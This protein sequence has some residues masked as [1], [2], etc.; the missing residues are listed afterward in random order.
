MAEQLN[1][2]LGK[3]TTADFHA[4][5]AYATRVQGPKTH[6]TSAVAPAMAAITTPGKKRSKKAEGSGVVKKQRK[7]TSAKATRP[8]NSYMAFRAYYSPIFSNFQQ[9]AI[10]PLLTLLWQGDHFQAKWTILAKA[11]SKIRDQQGKD[12][13]NLSKFLELV[14]PFIGIIA[15]ADYLSTM[16]W[17]M[18]EGENGAA[19]HRETTPDFSSFPAELRTT[20]VFVEDV[21]EYLQ[22][23]GYVA[24][25]SI[26]APGSA[27]AAPTLTMA[28]QPSFSSAA[29]AS[30]QANHATS[31]QTQLGHAGNVTDPA[32]MAPTTSEG[33][34]TGPNAA[35]GV[36]G[37]G[38]E[39]FYKSFENIVAELN[40]FDDQLDFNAEFYPSNDNVAVFNPGN[41]QF[42]TCD[43]TSVIDA[44]LNGFLTE[45][46][47]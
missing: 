17:K 30:M 15:P 3:L 7:E 46:V 21:I 44:D 32:L 6:G 10:S 33:V 23:I 24:N 29:Q 42:A 31:P 19:L 26:A 5:K 45:N 9:K 22:Q 4:L 37:A 1:Q 14:A 41:N 13:A 39:D 34:V 20:N 25:A 18:S 2:V 28:A 11:Y 38:D 12:N 8:L 40:Q 43:I 35:L 47:F 16:G 27:V 36:A